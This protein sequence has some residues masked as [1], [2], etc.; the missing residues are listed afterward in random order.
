MKTFLIAASTLIV[1][2]I[3]VL[4]QVEKGSDASTSQTLTVYSARHYDSDRSLYDAFT[5]KTGIGV[6]RVED[7]AGRLYERIRAEAQQ[8]PADV[9]ITVDAGNL[10]KAA[11]AN[12]FQPINS[13]TLDQNIPEHLR[14]PR[15]HWF[16]FSLRARALY[17][18]ADSG[19]QIGSYE[20]LAEERFKGKILVRS[21]MNLYNQSLVAAMIAAHGEDQTLLWCKALVENFARKPQSNDTGQLKALVAGEGDVAIANSYYY[22]RLLASDNP[23]DRELASKIRIIFPNQGEGQRGTHVNISGAG[24]LSHAPNPEAGQKFLEFLSSPE[25]QGMFA[26]ANHEYPVREDLPPE[27]ALAKWGAFQH[28]PVQA[29]LLGQHNQKAVDIM[30]RAGWR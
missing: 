13:S 27:D 28:D 24:L 4:T 25:G 1:L 2:A 18:R 26:E 29:S 3:L 14:H 12:L 21:S 10:W 9:L 16:G 30:D 20:S 7:K 8:C 22:A 6:K 17:V 19:L 23:E 15:G 5:Q 11:S